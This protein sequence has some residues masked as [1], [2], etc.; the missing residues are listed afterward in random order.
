MVTIQQLLKHSRKKKTKKLRMP[1]LKNSSS[2][3]SPQKKGV[4]FKVYT[5]TPRKPNSA[6]RKVARVLLTNG[7]KITSY[8]PGEKHNLQEHSIVLVRGGPVKDLPGVKY[9]CIRG[10]YDLEAV[11]TRKQGRSKYG[12]KKVRKN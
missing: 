10:K 6:Q 4:C 3:F 11:K 7:K 12:T 2:N 5:Q 9:H 1:A 8:I